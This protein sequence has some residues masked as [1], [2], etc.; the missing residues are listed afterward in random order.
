MRGVSYGLVRL[1]VGFVVWDEVMSSGWKVRRIFMEV[2]EDWS[3][4]VRKKIVIIIL[5]EFWVWDWRI[6]FGENGREEKVLGI[7]FSFLEVMV[8]GLVGGE[9]K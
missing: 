2:R 4:V 8:C 5:L 7:L 9:I 3:R 1:F 6:W